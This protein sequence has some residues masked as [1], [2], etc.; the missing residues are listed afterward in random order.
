MNLRFFSLASRSADDDSRSFNKTFPSIAH[1]NS[2]IS[3]NENDLTQLVKNF[4]LNVMQSSLGSFMISEIN[5]KFPSQKFVVALHF[6]PSSPNGGI[7]KKSWCGR[8]KDISISI[9]LRSHTIFSTIKTTRAFGRVNVTLLVSWYDLYRLR[10][11]GVGGTLNKT[12]HWNVLS[13][14][15]LTLSDGKLGRK[16]CRHICHHIIKL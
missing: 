3:I 4:E 5:F 10:N 13:S 1:F 16:F 12:R 14:R 6:F 15:K 8:K 9:K 2:W 7:I 11:W